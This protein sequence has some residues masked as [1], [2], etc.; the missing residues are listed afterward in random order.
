V[1]HAWEIFAYLP[2]GGWNDCPDT[3]ELMAVTKY[4]AEQYGA[5]PS[6]MSHDELEFFLPAPVPEN[7]A[8]ELA[9]EHY[10]FCPDLDQSSAPLGA[11]ADSLSRSKIWY[12]WWD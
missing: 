12:F 11:L 5:W 7:R 3:E 10:G 4:W 2:F 1:K 6:T 9:I 8:L